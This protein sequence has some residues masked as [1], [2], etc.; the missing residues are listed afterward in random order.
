MTALDRPEIGNILDDADDAAI[1]PRIVADGAG[2]DRVEITANRA[3]K[4]GVGCG[5]ERCRQ[6]SHQRFAALDQVQGRAAGR[7]WPQ[8]R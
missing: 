1:T 8:P 5:F 6:R 3:G 4:N 7:P 2:A